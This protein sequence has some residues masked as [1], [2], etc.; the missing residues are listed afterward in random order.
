MAID[1]N[2][3]NE[4]VAR[5]SVF[6]KDL[7]EDFNIIEFYQYYKKTYLPAYLFNEMKTDQV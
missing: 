1:R 5:E 7:I 6:V 4:K 3:I 2:K